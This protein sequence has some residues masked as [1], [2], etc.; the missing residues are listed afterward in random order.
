MS[1]H[2]SLTYGKQERT[3]HRAIDNALNSARNRQ[4]VMDKRGRI[5]CS[6]YELAAVSLNGR[7]KWE[8]ALRLELGRHLGLMPNANI[9]SNDVFWFCF[10]DVNCLQRCHYQYGASFK[11]L[12]CINSYRKGLKGLSYV[13][14]LEPAIYASSS[15]IKPPAFEHLGQFEKTISWHCH[16]LAWG[17]SRK[18]MRLRFNEIEA[19]GIYV[20][21][22]PNLKGCWAKFIQP[23]LISQKIGYMCKTPRLTNRVYCRNPDK[24]DEEKWEFEQE[25]MKSRPG[26]HI[27]YFKLLA[28]YTLDQLTFAGGDGSKILQTVK[29]PFVSRTKA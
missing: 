14:M 20:P 16:G 11:P 4:K 29:A 24:F 23:E 3:T 8:K 19:R 21:A 17:E 25:E 18:E 6:D 22:V 12:K 13:A 26:E 1:N 5:K 28:P 7:L 10:V 9:T 27:L 15:R 2:S